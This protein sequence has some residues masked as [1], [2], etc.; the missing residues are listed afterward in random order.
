MTQNKKKISTNPTYFPDKTNQQQKE[1][2]S[3]NFKNNANQRAVFEINSKKKKKNK[4][5]VLY[6]RKLSDY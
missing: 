6:R 3:W 4:K 5:F 2:F 1:L